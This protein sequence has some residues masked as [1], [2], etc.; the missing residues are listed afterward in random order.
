MYT[1][2][3]V[4]TDGS[5][6]ALA[7][8]A[9]A[10]E[11]AALCDARIVFY[12][13]VPDFQSFSYLMELLETDR[14][15]YLTRAA[16]RAERYLDETCALAARAGV[17]CERVHTVCSEPHAGILEAAAGHRCDLIVMASRSRRAV[18]MMIGS[19][20]LKVMAHSTIPV[21]AYR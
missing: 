19:E 8:A 9:H 18:A 21:L 3:L 20:T 16:E 4:P 2:L 11:L 6:A 10:V 5:D 12:H 1:R 15:A 17:E 7:A 14:R 13:A